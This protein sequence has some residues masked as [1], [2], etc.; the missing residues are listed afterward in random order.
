MNLRLAIQSEDNR[1]LFAGAGLDL[2]SAEAWQQSKPDVHLLLHAGKEV[3]AY[4][5][6]W[7]DSLPLVEGMKPAAIGHFEAL[8]PGD[9]S[10]LLHAA[11]DWI[12]ARRDGPIIGPINA[13]TWHKYR[14]VT[15]TKGR[16]PFFLE[17][18]HPPFYVD[19]WKAAGFTPWA[20]FHSACMPPQIEIDPRMERVSSRLQGAGVYIRQLNKD[21]YREEL[22]KL[23]SVA[24]VSFADNLLYTPISE[25][26]F[27]QL[28]QPLEG[29][30]RPETIWLAEQKGRCVGFC[31][32]IADLAQ[33]QRG[34]TVDTLIIKTLATLPDRPY[35]GLGILLTQTAH[36]AAAEA[37]FQSVIH[38]LMHPASR[39][40]HFGRDAM[41]IFRRY[42]LY[43]H[44]A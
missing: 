16:A 41:E 39:I 3:R 23:Y 6:I 32:A 34:Q 5:S 26:Q 8:N 43:Q 21:N 4:C 44:Q 19:A 14:L 12:T 38:G 13:N 1:D 37:G 10:A 18:E 42:T 2:L 27:L 35:A 31:F 11:T 24:R 33:A 17:P 28:Y 7:M 15:E 9:G 30:L 40:K 20:E 29:L 36:Q 22:K 25:A